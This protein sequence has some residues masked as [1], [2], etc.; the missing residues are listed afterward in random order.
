MKNQFN[1]N[2]DK[3]SNSNDLQLTVLSSIDRSINENI[4]ID[5]MVTT[6]KDNLP[7]NFRGVYFNY[8]MTELV[9]ANKTFNNTFGD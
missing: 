7:L 8:C 6:P 9:K 1:K 2:N 3:S 5:L 4:Y